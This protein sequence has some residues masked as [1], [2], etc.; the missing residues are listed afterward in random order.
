M[1]HNGV[2]TTED[3][4]R[5]AKLEW[6]NCSPEQVRL[7]SDGQMS[8]LLLHFE[9]VIGVDGWMPEGLWRIEEIPFISAIAQSIQTRRRTL[10][11]VSNLASSSQCGLSKWGRWVSKTRLL[12]K[13]SIPRSR[14]EVPPNGETSICTCNCST[15]AQAVFPG[16]YN[17]SL[18]VQPLRK[19]MSSPESAGRMALWAIEPSEFDI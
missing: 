14:K 16:T 1:S 12:Y 18:D 13:P 9:K 4:Q 6:Q 8:T 7:E 11:L 2:R 10:P 5:G 3:N 15:K 19:A 17:H